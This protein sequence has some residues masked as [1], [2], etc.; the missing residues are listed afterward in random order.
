MTGPDEPKPAIFSRTECEVTDAE[1]AKGSRDLARSQSRDIGADEDHRAGR[2]GS[3]RSAHA[4]A[5]ITATLAHS[6]AAAV[7]M[8]GAM[9]SLVRCDGDPQMPAP[10]TGE[11]AQKQRNHQA[12]ETHCGEIAYVSRES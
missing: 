6:D 2:T 1:Q 12:L 4:L 5:E 11:T 7:P 8:A 3:K 9:A 10:V